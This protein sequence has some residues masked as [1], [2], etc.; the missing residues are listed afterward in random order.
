[1]NIYIFS[2]PGI[3]ICDVL[4]ELTSMGF[5]CLPEAGSDEAEG[6]E[7]SIEPMVDQHCEYTY[8]GMGTVVEAC[9]VLRWGQVYLP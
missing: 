3:A 2:V 4:K 7:T 9:R 8:M 1:M 5:C 6:L